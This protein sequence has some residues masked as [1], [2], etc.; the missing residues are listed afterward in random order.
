MVRNMPNMY[1]ALD[2]IPSTTPY[3]PKKGK[4]KRK[5]LQLDNKAPGCFWVLRR[6]GKIMQ[7]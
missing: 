4:K 7:F 5:N 6:T 2:S 3:H 1:K